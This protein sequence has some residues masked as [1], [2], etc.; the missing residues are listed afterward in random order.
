VP[1][2]YQR[3]SRGIP[4]RWLQTVRQAILSVAPTFSARRMVREYAETMYGPTL[5]AKSQAGSR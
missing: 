2:F 3:D 5:S 4:V 1:R